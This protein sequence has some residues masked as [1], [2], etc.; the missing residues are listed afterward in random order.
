VLP[1]SPCDFMLYFCFLSSVLS[2]QEAWRGASL[3]CPVCSRVDMGSRP[4][5]CVVQDVAFPSWKRQW[6]QGMG[7][8]NARSY[9]SQAWPWPPPLP[10]TPLSA[11]SKRLG[12]FLS[13][14]I[15]DETG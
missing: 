14:S 5:S 11:L 15:T 12:S 9:Q 7:A 1:E 10:F 13:Q 6:P 2:T 4:A 8:V 3:D